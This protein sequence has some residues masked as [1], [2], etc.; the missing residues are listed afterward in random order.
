MYSYKQNFRQ[1]S[2]NTD[3]VWA[4]SVASKNVFLQAPTKNIHP[5]LGQALE[6]VDF[7]KETHVLL[8][9]SRNNITGVKQTGCL[10]LLDIQRVQGKL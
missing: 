1:W 3:I 7:L 9:A 2:P 10:Y 5:L 8:E 4:T 6:E